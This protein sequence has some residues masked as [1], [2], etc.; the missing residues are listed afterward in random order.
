MAAIISRITTVYCDTELEYFT[1]CGGA[2]K[3]LLTKNLYFFLSNQLISNIQCPVI[4]LCPGGVLSL[5]FV[6]FGAG[7]FLYHYLSTVC[8][9]KRFFIKY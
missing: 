5:G 4:L 6:N 7:I 9:L 1:T 8:I 3:F 2:V